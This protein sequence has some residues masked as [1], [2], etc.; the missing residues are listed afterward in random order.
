MALTIDQ[1]KALPLG[2]LTGK[3]LVAW[4]PYQ[5]LNTVY[6]TDP[7]RLQEGCTTAYGEITSAANNRY[8]IA[9]ELAQTDPTK[10]ST[11]LVKIITL[12]AVRNA[13]GSMQGISEK[14][15]ADFKWLEK[16]MLDIR[17]AQA[18]LPLHPVPS[19]GTDPLTNQPLPPPN[20]RP[21]LV[22]SNFR[23]RG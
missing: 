18:N 12:L 2:Y 21:E 22:C 23:T 5:I 3:D 4:C 16:T 15:A 13:M 19:Q 7:D 20:S 8:D 1:L 6:S 10:R 14:M 9:T 17:N 11:Y